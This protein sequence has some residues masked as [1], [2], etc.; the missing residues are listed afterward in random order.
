MSVKNTTSEPVF[1][2]V[3]RGDAHDSTLRWLENFFEENP[4]HEL[5]VTATMTRQNFKD[6]VRGKRRSLASVRG[7]RRRRVTI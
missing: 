6:L 1:A 3:P 5:V 7:A 2:V 4:N